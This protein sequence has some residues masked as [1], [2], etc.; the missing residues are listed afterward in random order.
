ME[1]LSHYT[2]PLGGITL[3]SDGQALTGLWFDGQKYFGAGLP[4]ERQEKELP[5]FDRTARWLDLYFSGKDPGSVPDLH[6]RTTPFRKAV[7]EALLTVPFGCTTTYGQLAAQAAERL[8]LP[9]SSARAV[10]GA[11]GHNAISLI[12]PC[13]RVL[14]ADGSLTGYAGGLDR[15]KR[16]LALEG[17]ALR[18]STHADLKN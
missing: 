1:Y 8:G 4:E 7:W 2:S 3:F 13:H 16:L 15:K 6:M 12:I 14:G 5:I 10:G 9:R 18:D 11:V 17:I